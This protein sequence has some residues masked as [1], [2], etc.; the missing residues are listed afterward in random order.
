M[1]YLNT[2]L[3]TLILLKYARS[4]SYT[5]INRREVFSRA[6]NSAISF[7][8][9]PTITHAAIE[10]DSKLSLSIDYHKRDRTKSYKKAVIREDIWYMTGKTPPLRLDPNYVADDGPEYNA[11]G[12]CATS[13]AG[14]SCTYVPLKQRIPGYSNYAF[15]IA[16]GAREYT[17]LGTLINEIM[18]D[19]SNEGTWEK[20]LSMLKNLNGSSVPPPIL[21]AQLK[22]VLMGTA[23]LTTPNY[24][25]PPKELLVARFYIN[26]T[27]FAVAEINEAL[28]AR[29]AA[30]ATQAWDFGKDSWN[31]Y[32]VLVNRSIVPKVGDKFEFI[33]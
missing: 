18:R 16:S 24:T 21:D 10:D 11:W 25:G 27:S 2:F 20:A 28:E 6:T 1:R 5:S 30:R 19:K 32:F 14:N 22:M 8:A 29:D 9:V 3:Q 13:S 26:E 15:N 17:R 31:S 12:A 7:L 33:S 23:M 4:L